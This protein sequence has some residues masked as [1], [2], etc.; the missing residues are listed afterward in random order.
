MPFNYSSDLVFNFVNK[1][2]EKVYAVN[3]QKTIS[4]L[5]YAGY[6]APPKFKLAPNISVQ[7]CWSANRGPDNEFKNG[8]EVLLNQWAEKAPGR[9]LYVWLYYTFPLEQADGGNFNCFPGFF[10]HEIGRQ[11]K[12]LYQLGIKGIF[13]CGYGQEVE[14]YVTFRLMDDPTL[15]VNQLLNEY[16]QRMYGPAAQAM[17]RI[18]NE[19]E[20]A[21]MDL[22]NY[23]AGIGDFERSWTYQGTPERMIKLHADLIT[24]K[25]LATTAPYR[26]RVTL[27]EK[28]VWSYMT[29]GAEQYKAKVSAP[30]PELNVPATVLADGDTE[31]VDW[32]KAIVLNEWFNFGQN[33]PATRRLA[34]KM[35][36][37]GKYL[38]VELSDPCDTDLLETASIVF[39][40]DDWEIFIAPQRGRPYRQYAVSPTGKVV[41]L[42]H[43]EVNFRNNVPLPQTTV[44]A[45]SIK[46]SQTWLVR[47]A[48]PLESVLPQ[49]IKPGDTIYMNIL[50]VASQKISP[51]PAKRFD[52]SSL[53]SHTS[54]HDPIRAAKVTLMK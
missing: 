42:S 16:F 23:P 19:I 45:T 12:L 32:S 28:G 18:Y 26:E 3:P 41:G 31:K 44:L 9:G 14:S 30:M 39:P 17:Q 20:S 4:T 7:F 47:L 22:K 53:V 11:F 10:A 33:T 27:W 5:A 13:H 40:A 25:K 34:G 50:R 36:H 51:N 52:I 24:A 37:D 43:A 49:A 35:V 29:A 15:D 46:H 6:S 54:V 38:Y 2:A 21:F 1:I 48:L 8:Q